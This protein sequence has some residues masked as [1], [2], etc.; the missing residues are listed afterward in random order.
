MRVGT[1]ALVR[2][3]PV[4][5]HTFGA[6]YLLSISLSL[7]LS[8]YATGSLFSQWTERIKSWGAAP[9]LCTYAHSLS[10]LCIHIPT[11]DSDRSRRRIGA[12]SR[13]HRRVDNVNQRLKEDIHLGINKMRILS[14]VLRGAA[15][16]R[17]RRRQAAALGEVRTVGRTAAQGGC[18]GEG[19]EMRRYLQVPLGVSRGIRWFRLRSVV[20]HGPRCVCVVRYID[21]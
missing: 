11:G 15:G 5:R 12:S 6:S 14:S 2:D 16:I 4:E 17:I 13:H 1:Y 20:C 10:F 9:R 8:L 18:A 7:S 21:L 19:G 3:F